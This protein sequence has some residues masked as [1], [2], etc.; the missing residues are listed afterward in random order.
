MSHF[1]Y[2]LFNYKYILNDKYILP[3]CILISCLLFFEKNQS[4]RYNSKLIILIFTTIFFSFFGARLLYLIFETDQLFT[5]LINYNLNDLIKF[6]GMTING[7][8][9]FAILAFYIVTL[10]FS[11][12]ERLRLWSKAAISVS[13]SYGLIK[14]SCFLKGCCWGKVSF[15]PWAFKY[16]HSHS[17]PI[18]GIPVHP[19]QLYESFLGFFI[20]GILLIKFN[21]KKSQSNLFILFMLYFSIGRLF[22]ELFRGDDFRGI[23]GVF[24]IST[25]QIISAIILII[26][27]INWI[28]R[29]K[30]YLH[31]KL[32]KMFVLLICIHL[33][34]CIV[35]D[36]PRESD[37]RSILKKEDFIVYKTY[38]NKSITTKN[39]L[40]VAADEI[41]QKNIQNSNNLNLKNKNNRIEELAFWKYLKDFKNI[42]TNI[43]YIPAEKV[44]Y[45]SVIKG[46]QYLESLNQPFDLIFLTHGFPNHLSTGEGYFLSYRELLYLKGHFNNINLVYLQS[47]FGNSLSEDFKSVGAKTVISFKDF[48]SNIFFLDVFLKF[49]YNNNSPELA[50]QLA[51]ENFDFYIN[52]FSNMYLI[53]ILINNNLI[54]SKKSFIENLQFPILDSN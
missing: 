39:I 14:I 49:Y 54:N 48:N 40:F 31:L 47:C 12:N 51:K 8:M 42:Y 41:I 7:S 2:Q 17:M 27:L 18:I 26:Y 34:G 15:L 37:Y 22:T 9:I 23:F 28:I 25:S 20:F 5:N 46:I 35:P 53:D 30:I 16:T 44:R 45:E 6:D 36:E 1:Y 13:F 4:R 32:N 29:S 24:Q 50:F 43:L 11:S 33:T 21:Q 38:K 10:L 19:V 52:N 3:F